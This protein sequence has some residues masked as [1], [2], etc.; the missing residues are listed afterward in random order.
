MLLLFDKKISG[1]EMYEKN[2]VL[3]AI[4]FTFHVININFTNR[5]VNVCFNVCMCVFFLFSFFFVTLLLIMFFSI[6]LN[7]IISSILLLIIFKRTASFLPVLVTSCWSSSDFIFIGRIWDYWNYF[8]S[9][10]SFHLQSSFALPNAILGTKN[11]FL[12][13]FTKFS[14]GFQSSW[15]RL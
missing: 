15:N 3:L 13:R 14:R 2:N 5:V 6:M 8:T 12:K 11:V 10:K 1:C 7:Q 4:S 9:M